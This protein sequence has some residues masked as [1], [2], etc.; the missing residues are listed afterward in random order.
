[1]VNFVNVLQI[2]KLVFLNFT[3]PEHFDVFSGR[4][5]SEGATAVPRSAARGPARAWDL[6]YVAGP[7]LTGPVLTRNLVKFAKLAKFGLMFG[8][9][10]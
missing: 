7:V 5:A 8:Y 3:L 9:F 4:Q 1:M 10:C 6:S 2:P